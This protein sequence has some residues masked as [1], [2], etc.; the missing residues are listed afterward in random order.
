MDSD[1][2]I[3]GETS[4]S[5]MAK[6]LERLDDCEDGEEIATNVALISFEGTSIANVNRK[7]S[8]NR[9]T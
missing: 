8:L 4:N 3:S 6:L 9:S 7:P 1:V 2:Q 5:I